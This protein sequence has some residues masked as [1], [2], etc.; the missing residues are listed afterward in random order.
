MM[1]RDGT[2]DDMADILR[3]CRAFYETTSYVEQAPMD[4]ATVSVLVNMCIDTGVMVLAIDNDEPVGMVGLLCLP[5]GFNANFNSAHETAWYVSPDSRSAGIATA[6]L[7]EAE[8]QCRTKNVVSIQMMTMAD[9]PPQ[10]AKLYEAFGYKLTESSF[11]KV[12]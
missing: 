2:V 9:S 5:F 10:A 1:L 7:K 4:D 12:L 8:V 3:M 11:T 6:L